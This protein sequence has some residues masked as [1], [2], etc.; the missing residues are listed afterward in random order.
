MGRR[1]A[2]TLQFFL[3]LLLVLAG[4]TSVYAT[5]L[6]AGNIIVERVGA[7]SERTYRIRVIVYTNTIGTTVLFGGEQ[8]YLDFGDGSGRVLVPEI[9]DG[10]PRYSVID[11]PRGIA[12]AYYEITHTYGGPGTYTISYVEP[13]R[14]EGVINMDNS[15]N[16]TFYIETRILIDPVLG[17][18]TPANLLVPPVDR[19]CSGV[20]WYHN[21]GAYDPDG[22]SISYQMVVPFRD[23]NATVINYTS[24][25][26]PKYYQNYN[27]GNEEGN[28][29]PLFSIDPIDGTITWDA[30]GGAQIGEYNIAFIVIEWRRF[31][32]QWIRM[33]FVRRDMQI[34]V[35]DCDNE[36]PELE[37]PEDVCIEA[38]ETLKRTIYGS[39]PDGDEVKIEA[40]SEIFNFPPPPVNSP[41]TVDPYPAV[42]AS[43]P[44]TLDFEWNT[45]CSHVKDQPYQVVFKITDRRNNGAALTYFKTWRITVVGPAPTW[46]DVA[47]N[48]STRSVTLK[49]DPYKCLNADKMQIW[50]KVDGT[51]YVPG[52]CETG[53]PEA[54]GYKLI[55]TVGIKAPG[56]VPIVQY[57]DN[58]DGMGLAPGAR[59]C[60]RLVA[61]YPLPKGGESY[62]SQD[63]CIGP[64]LADVPIITNVSVLKTD[65]DDG[66]IEVRWIKPFDLNTTNFPEP[67]TYDVYRSTGFTRN[68]DS[69]KVNPVPLAATSFTDGGLDTEAQI[70]NYSITAIDADG[71]TI[72]NSFVAS[73]VRL[74]ANSQPDQIQLNWTAAVPWSNQIPAHPRHLIFRGPEGS[75]EAD[76]KLIDS[77]DATIDGLTYTDRGQH[78]NRPLN[79]DSLYCYRILTRGGYG[80]PTKIPE[81]LENYSQMICV[82]PS[83]DEAPCKPIVSI[84]LTNCENFISQASTCNIKTFTNVLSWVYLPGPD[85]PADV[86]SYKIYRSKT[87]D[88]EYSYLGS[89]AESA[90][91]DTN[92]SSLAYCYRVSAVD[93]SG[94]ESDMSDVV[95]NDNCPTYGLPNVFSPNIDGFNDNFSAYNGTCPTPEACSIPDFQIRG[96]ARFVEKVRFRVYNRWGQRVYAFES[97]SEG[98]GK[99]IY[100]NWDGRDENGVKLATAVYYYVAEVTFDVVNPSDKVKIYKGWVHLLDDSQ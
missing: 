59:Y 31:A 61:I 97:G 14:N 16:T 42:F 54:L 73:S 4:Q 30:P 34:I 19:A 56:G 68:N 95:C 96:C 9:G 36:R 44:T 57:K 85:C 63:T 90:Y 8:D 32:G 65:P 28:G 39:D 91:N 33:G 80:N 35:E 93:R 92:L 10:D 62:V 27:Q 58:N 72:G 46:N 89:T 20:A 52:E 11:E 74:G 22:D 53:M 40:F 37:I 41:A 13:N 69:T 94:N 7:C 82:Q 49:W 75:T 1:L 78:N 51:A 83:D 43:S 87:A 77:V 88:G 86:Q 66:Q 55:A 18:S 98:S 26:D 64:I 50:R 71:D 15:V 17:C 70:Y 24:P 45:L 48:P 38:G 2:Y 99:S 21:P 12:T 84:Q 5:H 81:P 79:R 76:L 23:R 6:R 25:I 3:P 67:Y 29:P 100:I 47:L 60:Y